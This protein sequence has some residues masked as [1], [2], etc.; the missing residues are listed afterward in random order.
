MAVAFDTKTEPSVFNLKTPL[1]A[2][3]RSMDLLSRTDLMTAHIKV[4]AEGG[5]NG[6]HTHPHEDHIFVVLAGE[7]TFHLGK[8]ERQQVVC[9]HEGIMLPGGAFYRFETSSDEPLVLLRVGAQV[10]GTARD[11]IKPDGNPIP[12]D[13]ADNKHVE[14]AI[15]PG[16]FFE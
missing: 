5:E 12:G 6:L 11:R 16:K 9:K 3:G 8:E 10:P 2:R 7:A 4:Y 1:L 14:P 13:S 15:L